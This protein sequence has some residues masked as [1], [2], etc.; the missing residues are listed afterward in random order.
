[1]RMIFPNIISGKTISEENKDEL[2]LVHFPNIKITFED[3]FDE[4]DY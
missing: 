1:M 3:L 4:I 2:R